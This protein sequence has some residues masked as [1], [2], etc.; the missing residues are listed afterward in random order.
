M[1]S[2]ILQ[3]MERNEPSAWRKACTVQIVPPAECGIDDED[4]V[5]VDEVVAM[6][7]GE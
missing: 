6:L 2:Q 7:K 5:D 3:P 1:P 4:A